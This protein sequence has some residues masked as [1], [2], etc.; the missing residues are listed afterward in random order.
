MSSQDAKTPDLDNAVEVIERFGGIRPMASKMDVPVTTV[1]GWKKR[2]T[3]PEDRV[4]DVMKAAAEH[5][6]DLSGLERVQA[7]VANENA[8]AAPQ[9]GAG[10]VQGSVSKLEKSAGEPHDILMA[11][12]RS[13]T[14][15]AIRTSI[16][17]TVILL[18]LTVAAAV[19]M[20]APSARQVSQ[21]TVELETMKG[22]VN[23]LGEEVRDVNQRTSFMRKIIPEELQSKV[24]ELQTQARNVQNNVQQLTAQAETIQ[25]TLFSEDAGSLS[26]RLTR[27]EQE[28]DGFKNA[29]QLAALVDRVQVL[30]KTVNGQVQL[31]QAIKELTKM[32]GDIDGR[33]GQVAGDVE[34]NTGRVTTLEDQL[35]KAQED[36]TALGKTLEGMSPEDMK[37][38][39]TLLA[40]SQLRSSLNREAPF[41]EDLVLLEKVAGDDPEFHAALERLA[42]HANGGVL[43]SEGLSKEF[44]GLAGDIVVASL[45]GEDV[46]LWERTK[47][48]FA[49]ALQIEKDGQ[50]MT[51]TE[52]QS[53]VAQAQKQLDDGDVKGAIATLEQLDGQAAQTAQPFIEQAQATAMTGDIEGALQGMILNNLGGSFGNIQMP[54]MD[55]MNAQGVFDAL[56]DQVT[57]RPDVVKDDESGFVILP[58]QQGGFKGLKPN[59]P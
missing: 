33:V 23:A 39:V 7:E 32:V 18:L 31:D 19:F 57:D 28:F 58:R 30:E 22:D 46:S 15:N 11:E 3:I 4:D 8:Q 54:S 47:A 1:Q 56:K 16:W 52:T 12:I 51:G 41:Q 53:V 42:P 36:R 59:Q 38:A 48:R 14:Q 27:L 25:K 10:K 2:N 50:L 43:T 34:K 44:K 29:P 13:S 20:F 9:G 49:K 37:A 17:A 55:G 5:N 6:I 35:A 21:N 40:F 26:Q 24:D 45:K